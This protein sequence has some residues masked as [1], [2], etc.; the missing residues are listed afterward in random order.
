MMLFSLSVIGQDDTLTLSGK[1]APTAYLTGYFNVCLGESADIP[2]YLTNGPVWDV[3]FSDGVSQWTVTGITT[4]TY[5]LSVSPPSVRAYTVVSVIAGGCSGTSS[6]AAT[7]IPLTAPTIYS[8][9]CSSTSFC[10]GSVSGPF[11]LNGSVN[12]EIYSLH[13]VGDSN[14]IPGTTMIG[15]GSPLTWTGIGIAGTVEAVAENVAGCQS[16]MNNQITLT[17]NP[18]PGAATAING[19]TSICGG[20]TGVTY[21]IP[22][23]IPNATSYAWSVPVG[24]T[25]TANYGTSITVNFGNTSGNITVSGQN[26]CQGGATFSIP[27]TVNSAPTVTITA[28]PSTTICAG[29]N[30]DL[31]S[32]SNQSGSTFAWSTGQT[33]ATINATPVTNATYMVT[34]TGPNTCSQTANVSINVV[35]IPTV[36]ITMP[37]SVCLQEHV[38]L[39]AS[40]LGGTWTGLGVGNDTLYTEICGVGTQH[41]TYT[42]TSGGCSATDDHYIV[43]NPLPYVT[44]S[45][46][47]GPFTTD[48]PPLDMAAYVYPTPGSGSAWMFD[49]PAGSFIGS[50]FNANIAGPGNHQLIY[51]FTHLNG[52]SNN[53]GIYITINTVGIE[54]IDAVE[55][56]VAFP[57]PT[58][59]QITLSGINTQ[60]VK[61][62]YI[63]DN[64]GQVVYIATA[65]DATMTMDISSFAAG[66][67]S[68]VFVDDQGN[69]IGLRNI[70][71]N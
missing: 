71:R 6:G 16:V 52:C 48:T 19:P 18:L 9:S 67:Y 27:I 65:D 28:S 2:V 14:A 25:I 58:D 66:K 1:A 23:S 37:N 40:P 42:V 12:G 33:G 24:S 60:V 46:V 63:V 3:T 29:D 11:T 61:D 20:T 26:N 15:T 57:N 49:G 56:I 55:A 41:L 30:V 54:D 8:L 17:Q 7:V 47:P 31:T 36:A 59:G 44:W 34:V 38:A 70:I 21:S 50:V 64:I 51:T 53:A 68:I 45:V 62:I 4:S 43:V 5:H 13:L 39:S 69:F 22:N 32:T 10:P 35:P